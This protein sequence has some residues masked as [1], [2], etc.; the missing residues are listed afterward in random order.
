[1][2]PQ[3]IN[4]TI[5]TITKLKNWI[6]QNNLDIIAID[7]ITYLSDERGK[8]ND[9]KTTSLTN[10]AEDLMSLSME[11]RVPILTVVQANRGGVTD[12]NSEDLPE[13]ENIR[14]SDGISYNASKIISLKQ[15]DNNL[16]IQVKKQRNGGV[17]SKIAYIW[18][19]NV[20]E[21]IAT[22]LNDNEPIRRR[23]KKERKQESQ[24]DVF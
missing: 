14:D 24:E 2:M 19:P 9:N 21:F 12:R 17:G 8:R 18:N 3:N 13:L 22:A 4:W 6:K 15:K 23:E 20:G 5:I 1:M 7:G 10:I 16:I 11:M